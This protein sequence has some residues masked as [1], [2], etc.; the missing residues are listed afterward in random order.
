M[1]STIS[2]LDFSEA[3]QR[4]AREIV[5][6]F[7]QQ[8]S[9]DE[10]GIG[11]VRDALSDAMFPG[12][13][14]V[15][16]RA[17]YFLFVPW[18]F[19]R[20]ERRSGSASDLVVWVQN[21]ER[22]LIEALRRDGD[23]NGLIGRNAGV[24]LKI[25][26]SMIY[27]SGLQRF[28]ILRRGATQEQVIGATSQPSSLEE[29]LTELVDR[30]DGVWDPNIPPPPDRFFEMDVASFV[31]TPAEADWLSERIVKSVPGTL[32]AWLA[33]SGETLTGTLA[34]WDDPLVSSAPA[35]SREAVQHAERFSLVLLGAA[36]LYNLLLAERAQQLGL[37]QFA[38]KRDEFERLLRDWSA[39]MEATRPELAS[40]DRAAFWK[41]I[42]EINPR[43]AFST[44]AF[45]EHWIDLALAT[46]GSLA[47]HDEARRMVATRERQQKG[48][49]SRLVNDRLLQQWGGNSGGKRLTFRWSQVQQILND[50]GTGRSA[51]AGS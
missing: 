22:R 5:Q 36:L 6:L 35:A 33:E 27:W 42:A 41:L 14:V 47:Q 2:W 12:I 25:V 10:L 21:Q 30:G 23:E 15:Q 32:L 9:R 34:A 43:V 50:I 1:A 44:R 51:R 8:D 13:S 49:Q 19:R 18:L 31:L 16:S 40:W 20:A 28:E 48:S 38:D 45:V 24:R 39:E 37:T 29:A 11:T 3:D 7:S 4:R 26:P 46:P 17:R